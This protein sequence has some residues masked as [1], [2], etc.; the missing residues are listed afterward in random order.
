MIKAYLI[1]YKIIYDYYLKIE[2]EGNGEKF[3]TLLVTSMLLFFN[4]S[5]IFLLLI[6]FTATCFTINKFIIILIMLSIGFLN[7]FLFIRRTDLYSDI[8]ISRK[9][10]NVAF[11]I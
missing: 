9:H 8:K 2:G 4:F 5:S 10:K 3:T 7:Y 1:F 6:Y 11:F